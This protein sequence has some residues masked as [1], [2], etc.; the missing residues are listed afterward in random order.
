MCATATLLGRTVLCA[1][2]VGMVMG[3][4]C[5]A[6][7]ARL[8]GAEVIAMVVVSVCAVVALSGPIVIAVRQSGT[9]HHVTC[10]V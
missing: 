8:V 3:V 6:M 9:V 10:G 7:Q 5:T 1:L 2:L 4:M